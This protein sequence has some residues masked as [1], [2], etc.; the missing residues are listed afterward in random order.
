MTPVNGVNNIATRSGSCRSQARGHAK[1]GISSARAC[2]CFS[3]LFYS[4]HLPSFIPHWQLLTY[5][6][7][8][9]KGV[10]QKEFD[11]IFSV[12]VSFRSLFLTLLSLFCQTPFAGLLLRQGDK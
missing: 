2:V 8:A 12:L 4:W 7:G 1:G 5:V 10:R 6:Q 9:P 3:N 11:H